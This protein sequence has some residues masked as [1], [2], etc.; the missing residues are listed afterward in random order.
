MSKSPAAVAFA[1][2]LALL[3]A[4]AASEFD[5][6]LTRLGTEELAAWVTEPSVLDAIR[7]QNAAN[8]G[9]TQAQIDTLDADWRAQVGAAS[10]PMI[11]ALLEN[12]A[13]VWLRGKKDEAAGLVTEVFVMDQHGLNVAQS[14]VTSDYWQ[15]DEDKFTKTFGAGPGAIHVSEVE[16]DESSQTYQSQVSMTVVDP[17]TGA[18]IG[19]VTFGVDV[20]LLP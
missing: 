3:P 17:Q 20:S 8:A 4:Y 14:D 6:P 10:E 15:G 5:A 16:L 9:L 7:A 19:A 18:A 2:G 11:D 13:S 12:P 1:A